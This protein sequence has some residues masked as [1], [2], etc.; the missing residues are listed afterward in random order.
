MRICMRKGDSVP[1]P[2]S[3]GSL[4]LNK[5]LPMCNITKARWR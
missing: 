2:T 4:T 5:V 3:P 1:P